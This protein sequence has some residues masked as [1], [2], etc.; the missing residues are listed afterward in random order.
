ML[1]PPHKLRRALLAGFGCCVVAGEPLAAQQLAPP[2]YD[3]RLVPAT[4]TIGAASG[5]Y[6]AAHALRAHLPYARCA[7]CD[8][9]RLPA[10]DR[11]VLGPVRLSVSRA[12]DVT[13]AATVLG[14]GALL[15][16]RGSRASQSE[17]LTVFAEAVATTLAVTAWAKVAFHRPRP[18][19]YVAPVT[20]VAADDGR[21]F[22]SG[23][24]SL[25]FAAAAAYASIQQRRG[26]GNGTATTV[27]VSAA[28]VTAVLRV[29]ARRHFPTDV[30]AGAVLGGAVGWIVPA[31]HPIR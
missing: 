12:S 20:R 24:A 3:V 9:S 2:R 11:A 5:V 28:T 8:P 30:A 18:V 10:V 17:D 14:A 23:H 19:R 21:S 7:P 27:L 25:A 6:L 26:G 22:P 31:V 13:V 16:D 29:V 4:L 15:L 1:Q